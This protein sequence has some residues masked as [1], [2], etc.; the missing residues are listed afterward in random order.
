MIFFQQLAHSSSPIY[1]QY[2]P[3][4]SHETANVEAPSETLRNSSHVDRLL[5]N[6]IVTSLSVARAIFLKVQKV[7]ACVNEA[8]KSV[9]AAAQDVAIKTANI[10]M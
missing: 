5:L 7:W 2:R 1:I 6:P 4:T 9:A 10:S 3:C 8:E